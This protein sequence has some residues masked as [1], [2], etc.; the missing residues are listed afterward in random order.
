MLREA[1]TLDDKY[2]EKSGR[3]Y[4]NGLQALVRIPMVQKQLD[5][6]N[7][8]NTASFISGYRGSPLGGVDIAFQQAKKF[9]EKNDIVFHAGVNEDLGATAVWGSQQ[10]HL[11]KQK[12]FD[13][14]VGIWYGKGPGVDRSLDALKHANAAGSSPYGGVL[15]LA[16]DDHACKSSTF[17]HQSEQAF[18]HAMIPVINPAGI[19]DALDLALHAI[20]MSRYSGCWS[21]MKIISDMAD[22]S[23]TVATDPFAMQFK[24]PDDF[25]MPSGGL[26]IRWYDPP[27]EQEARLVN[28]KLPAVQAYV[29]ANGLDRV[30]FR[31]KKKMRLGIVATGKAFQDTMQALE[32]MG[33]TPADAEKRGI[34]LYK[35]A[36]VWPLEQSGVQEFARGADEILV[37]EE[38]RSLIENQLKEALYHMPAGSRPR[39][40]GK[41]D[42]KG[43]PLLADIYELSPAEI[44]AA[45]ASRIGVFDR[46]KSLM[47]AAER[48]KN[49]AERKYDIP[50]VQRIPHYCSGCPHNTSTKVPEGSRA[51]A[52]I[53]CH[54]MSMWMGRNTEMFTQMGGEGVPWI[55]QAP[56]TAEEHVFTNLGDGTYFHSGLLAI[57][58]AIAGNVNITYKILY[59]DAVA[60][61]G[62]QHVDGELS[63]A[64]IARQVEAEGVRRIV[65]MS[66]QPEKYGG[67]TDFPSFTEIEHRDNLDYVQRQLRETKGV[68]VLIYDQTCAAEKRRRRKRGLMEDPVKRVVINEKVCEGCGDCSVQSNCLSILPVETEFGRK[69]QIDQSSCNKDFSCVKG[70]C[71]SFVTVYGKGLRKPEPVS[72]QTGIFAGL[73]KPELP[74]LTRATSILVTGIGGTGVVT[75]GAILAMAAHLEDKG[76]TTMDQTG[77]A[78]KGGAVTSHVRIAPTPEDIYTVRI[79]S[80]SADSVIGCDLLVTA[81][82]DALSRMRK[83]ES[84][85][86]LNTYQSPTGDFSRNPDWK[87]PFDE[88]VN[89]VRKISGADNLDMLD[90]TSL[91][92]RLLGDSIATN[93]FMLGF[94]WQK[95]LVPLSDD[96]ILKAIDLNGVA[97]PMN[98]Q[99]FMWGRLAAHDLK[100]V[101]QQAE[102]EKAIAEE[103]AKLFDYR[104]KSE[105]LDEMIARRVSDLTAYQNAAYAANYQLLVDHIREAELALANDAENLPLTKAVARYGYKLMA[106]KDEYEVARLYTDGAFAAQIKKLFEDGHKLKFNLAPPLLAR[107]DP[108]TGHL[109][110]SEFGAWIL[111]AFKVLASLRGLRGT[112]LDVFGMTAERRMERRLAREY[113]DTMRDLAAVLTQENYRIAV[114]IAEL[115][116]QIRG[117][118]HIKEA[119]MAAAETRRAELLE[120]FKN[121]GKQNGG[122]DQAELPAEAA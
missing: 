29:R 32:E 113:H 105:T 21:A 57:R 99:A 82:G 83:G 17:P 15:A 95:A 7:G 56:F 76:A 80:G 69:R 111:P 112:W 22:S 5:A 51:L 61:T 34:G 118:G 103:E 30:I 1:V 78:Q 39:V 37:I 49:A 72:D 54:Y 41:S 20:A 60:M 91:A 92:T 108:V 50:K 40:C 96:A 26:N 94:A 24:T 4:L 117:Y 88:M 77:L 25:E 14:V 16:G 68:S 47:A 101:L 36:V 93:M 12:K 52:G 9:W 42:E 107:R 46:D 102:P 119:N 55:G 31:P 71:P 2:T 67:D 109:R 62:G 28:Y 89:R 106:Y 90:A 45:L 53:G 3:I 81:D 19:G 75:I 100:A 115:P 10:L 87:I 43:K 114:E 70:F 74:A 64:M 110:K 84:K 44:A 13:G 97:V 86:V 35:V 27:V 73:P 58:A 65:V 85:V 23:A 66:D 79:D 48:L 8:L 120:R 104:R 18:I 116:E 11:N 63:V 33:I 98:K 38:K 6:Q 121:A 122:D 59:N